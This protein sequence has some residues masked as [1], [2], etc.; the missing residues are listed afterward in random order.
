M[1]F[2]KGSIPLPAPDTFEGAIARAVAKVR[3]GWASEVHLTDRGRMA[4]VEHIGIDIIVTIR[5]P[6]GSMQAHVERE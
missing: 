2:M 6:D 1:E 4:K 5:Q 3:S